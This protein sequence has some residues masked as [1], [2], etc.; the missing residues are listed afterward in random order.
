MSTSTRI[1]IVG[2]S[3][4]GK[5]TLAKEIADILTLPHVEFDSYRHGPKWLETPDSVFRQS[6]QLALAGESWVAD[7][8]YSFVWDIVW[9]RTTILIWLDYSI[10]T[11]LWRLFQRTVRRGILREELWNGN[12]ENILKH[13]FTRDS[14]FI[15]ALKTHWRRR[16]TIVAGLQ[17][18]EYSHIKVIH[19]QS[20]RSTRNLV[21]TL[22]SSRC[23]I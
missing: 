18:P 5:T 15:W 23:T 1:H 2:T 12:K 13:F 4:S 21:K 17:K 22:E 8:N 10:F 3:G 6:L 11:V 7:G 9:P 14:L 19:L 20:G 16:F